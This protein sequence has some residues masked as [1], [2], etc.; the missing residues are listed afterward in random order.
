MTQQEQESVTSTGGGGGGV[1]L[2]LEQLANTHLLTVRVRWAKELGVGEQAVVNELSKVVHSFK[3]NL[4]NPVYVERYQYL[5][6]S[7]R[8]DLIQSCDLS[9]ENATVEHAQWASDSKGNKDY[10]IVIQSQFKK[11][12]A[13]ERCIDK[14]VSI[15]K[16]HSG[17]D[18][19]KVIEAWSISY[20]N[21]SLTHP[22][23]IFIGNVSKST[24][25]AELT[26]ICEGFGPIMSIKLI[27]NKSGAPGRNKIH[28][29]ATNF[30]FVSFQLGSQAA[31]CINE[32]N[33]KR[34]NGSDLLVNYHVERKEREK[35]YW[36]QFKNPGKE[37]PTTMDNNSDCGADTESN[38]QMIQFPD[39]NA[40]DFKC[41]F[42]GN[43]PRSTTV[44][45][46]D[47]TAEPT[48]VTVESVIAMI[49]ERMESQLP[50]LEIS[51]SYFPTEHTDIGSNTSS[52][53]GRTQLKGYGFIKLPTHDDAV[54][55]I[56]TL[57]GSEWH[58]HKL[59]VNRA[60]Q[61][62][63]HNL[64]RRATAF[65]KP[66]MYKSPSISNS[67]RSSFLDVPQQP[68]V[69]MV[70][71]FRSGSTPRVF[72]AQGAPQALLPL[73]NNPHQFIAP[74]NP[75][76]P[77]NL[78]M[79]TSNQQESNLYI[80]HIPLS[81][82][83]PEL[84]QFYKRFGKIIS[85]K[86]I[87]IGGSNRRNS[88][89]PGI[90]QEDSNETNGVSN[91]GSSKGYGFVC[92]ENPLDASRAILATNGALVDPN[93]VLEVS[94]ANKKNGHESGDRHMIDVNDTR[95]NQKFLNALVHEQNQVML[96]SSLQNSQ[97][98][99]P[100]LP[101][102]IRQAPGFAYQQATTSPIPAFV[103][104]SSYAPIPMQYPNHTDGIN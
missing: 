75:Y 21:H 100:P 37:T 39:E 8:I 29:T 47:T 96:M 14:T 67:R 82:R 62:R 34:I 1:G 4:V 87:T 17:S 69:G 35:L 60:I 68:F 26:E 93:H 53:N 63:V 38:G 19:R 2:Q 73:A 41:V 9:F 85:A 49:R 11:R 46:V 88:G 102:V 84:Y 52:G 76:F 79:P 55:V 31:K 30:G 56:E 24:T 99:S 90:H 71:F 22:G 7:E 36:D 20:N 15:L 86:I 77:S 65:N 54:C 89:S 51:S 5:V 43:L 80:K 6:D 66:R 25:L 94:F 74:S 48:V 101:P 18:D 42:V 44:I 91:V 3:G 23:N 92:F 81:W 45:T 72:A 57:N 32:L 83:D 16:D 13:M 78:P 33:G 12:S 59:T 95:Y 58:D 61:N 104:V 98:L 28:E 103:P 97:G 50:N 10:S 70:P 27:D 40:D 64:R